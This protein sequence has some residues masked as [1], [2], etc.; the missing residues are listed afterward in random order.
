MIVIVNG[1]HYSFFLRLR[2][3]P[4]I[5]VYSTKCFLLNT[6]NLTLYSSSVV[7]TILSNIRLLN[8]LNHCI[9]SHLTILF[10]TVKLLRDRR[11]G[12]MVVFSWAEKDQ[13]FT[14]YLISTYL[15]VNICLLPNSI[16]Q[17]RN[18]SLKPVPAADN[19]CSVRSPSPF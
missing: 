10:D 19:S 15:F 11:K 7:C 13:T 6:F 2:V 14:P 9:R 5:Q 1:L 18:M 12:I 17:V 4:G 3:S 16:F 8:K